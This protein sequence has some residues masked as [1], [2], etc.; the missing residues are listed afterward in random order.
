MKN[1]RSEE[2]EGSARTQLVEE[3]IIETVYEGYISAPMA[4][5][6]EA[7]VRKLL[8]RSPSAH[9]LIDAAAAT[10]IESG[11]GERRTAMFK[12]F[13]DPASR[14][15]VVLSSTT[16]RMIAATFA[17]AFGVPLKT[18]DR[19]SDALDYLRGSPR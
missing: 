7:A 9:W 18:F 15:A 19:R 12:L 13:K 1:P 11:P 17:F 16:L 6:V 10:G 8:I 2:R 14:F 5:D 4:N 3:N